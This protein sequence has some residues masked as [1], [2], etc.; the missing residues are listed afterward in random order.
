MMK[1]RKA[2][3][4]AL[5]SVAVEAFVDEMV[6]H[7]RECFP[8][9]CRDLGPV[10]LRE[11]LRV[12]VERAEA[13]GFTNEREVSLYL[14]LMLVFGR[15]FDRKEPWARAILEDTEPEDAEARMERLHDAGVEQEARE[16]TGKTA[17]QCFDH[18]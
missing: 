14:G 7:L 8:E 15:D 11:L 4:E 2:Q 9:P 3:M 16:A 10:G 17:V 6:V 1:V 18:S 13:H 12:G 5:E